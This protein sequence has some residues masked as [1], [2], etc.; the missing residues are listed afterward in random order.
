MRI[1][2]TYS[3][4]ICAGYKNV[5]DHYKAFLHQKDMARYVCSH[6]FYE[7][8]C[9]LILC[10]SCTTA[11]AKELSK[12][13]KRKACSFLLPSYASY[14]FIHYP[15]FYFIL[16]FFFF[17]FF[18]KFRSSWNIRGRCYTVWQIVTQQKSNSRKNHSCLRSHDSKFLINLNSRMDFLTYK[19]ILY[20]WIVM[21]FTRLRTE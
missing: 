1:I 5:V 21:H 4:L 20:E 17:F 19:N 18:Y 14:I 12:K 6:V 16:C 2:Y 11:C 9:H 8:L 7:A 13:I 15:L 3:I 10:L